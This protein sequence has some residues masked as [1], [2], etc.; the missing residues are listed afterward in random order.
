MAS[1]CK[2]FQSH[3]GVPLSLHL[4]S[5]GEWCRQRLIEVGVSDEILLQAAELIGKS[6]DIGKYTE[7]FQERVK[8]LSKGKR[9]WRYNKELYSHAPLSAAYTAWAARQ[10]FDDPF[11]VAASMVCVYRHHSNLQVRFGELHRILEGIL[12]NPNYKRQVASL[13]VCADS[14]SA[15]LETLGLPSLRGFLQAF[16]NGMQD[17]RNVLVQASFHNY[18]IN[19][20][21]KLLLFFSVLIDSDKKE[22]AGLKPVARKDMLADAVDSYVRVR[23]GHLSGQMAELRKELYEEVM[24]ALDEK[25]RGAEIPRII[26]ITAPTGSGKTLIAL[27]TALKLREKIFKD[28]GQRARIIYILPYINIIEQTYDVFSDVLGTIG[29]PRDDIEVLLKHHHLYVPKDDGGE[30][31]LEEKLMLVESWESEVVVTTFVQFLETLI[32]TRNRMLKKFHKLY[33][34]IIILDEV[35]AIPVE[36]WLLVKDVVKA[37]AKHSYIIFMTATM[38]MMLKEGHELVQDVGKYF[39]KLNRLN[40]S[41]EQEEK[42][43]EEAADYILEKWNFDGSLLAV[44]NKISTSIELYNAIKNRLGTRCVPLVEGGP[45]PPNGNVVVAY[46]STNIIPRERLRRISLLKNL[47]EDRR[48]VICV[49][50]QVVEAGVDLDFDKVVRDIAPLDSIIQAGGRCNRNWTRRC[51]EVYIIKLVDEA[52]NLDSIRIYGRLTIRDITEP[53]LRKW[54]RWGEDVVL[55]RIQE[56]FRHATEKLGAEFSDESIG[57]LRAIRELDLEKLGEFRLIKE[58]PR[59]AVFVELDQGAK[60]LLKNFRR[61]WEVR[62]KSANHD[63]VYRRRALLRAYRSRLEEYLVETWEVGSLPEERIVDEIDVRYIPYECVSE[64]Y[65]RETGLRRDGGVQASFW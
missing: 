44:V 12:D 27:S 25:L 22:A 18:D 57:L 48:P 53:L 8:D 29:L 49:S 55:E 50:T 17:V 65:D 24:K 16:E 42:T 38:P 4:R 35:Q 10:L 45:Q 26:T 64:Y 2:D 30:G 58:E 39:A 23:F 14:I 33:G 28:T 54:Q 60:D 46:L 62:N 15:E 51:G 40:Y 11:I 21:N 63:D 52:G 43:V 59:A 47:L 36:Y 34:S 61:L 37:L 1:L 5:V 6:H 7:Y 41:Y 13:S 56:Y 19:D 32:G 31:A 3:P 9:G 20:L